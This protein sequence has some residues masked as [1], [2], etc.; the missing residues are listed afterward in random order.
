MGSSQTRDGTWV[1]SIGK[2]I[3]NHWITREVPG[4][5]SSEGCEGESVQGCLLGFVDSC[6]L[7]V[8]SHWL[9][10]CVCVCV[11]VC[12]CCN[13]GA[14]TNWY[15]LAARAGSSYRL[16][17]RD[18]VLCLQRLLAFLGSLSSHS[19]FVYLD[20]NYNMVMVRTSHSDLCFCHLTP[21]W[22]SSWVVHFLCL[23]LTRTLVVI[24]PSLSGFPWWFRW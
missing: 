14:V 22:H 3:L 21:L 6:L 10:L 4:L 2:W 19:F 13:M 12:V 15:M 8:S 11:C 17:G 18:S 24:V 16:Q 7:P 20:D 23:P 1:S 9:P 5:M